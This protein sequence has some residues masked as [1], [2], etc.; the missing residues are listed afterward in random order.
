[1]IS[2]DINESLEGFRSFHCCNISLGR[3]DSTIPV[4]IRI[5]SE[6]ARDAE[7]SE[8]STCLFS[9]PF[10]THVEIRNVR[11]GEEPGMWGMAS[12]LNHIFSCFTQYGASMISFMVF[13]FFFSEV[14]GSTQVFEAVDVLRTTKWA[15][16][17]DDNSMFS[18]MKNSYDS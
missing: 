2:D 1:M 3:R 6:H 18:M 9:F 14:F 13:F 16:L 11:P 15:D 12:F 10:T 8:I 17:K 4:S 5:S 7:T